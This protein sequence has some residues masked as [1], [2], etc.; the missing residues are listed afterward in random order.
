MHEVSIGSTPPRMNH[1]VCT[2]MILGIL[3]AHGLTLGD[4]IMTVLDHEMPF[5]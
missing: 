4:F 3:Q 5:S 2:E 1:L